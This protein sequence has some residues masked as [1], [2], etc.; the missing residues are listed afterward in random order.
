[1]DTTGLTVRKNKDQR[2]E[3]IGNYIIFWSAVHI[4]KKLRDEVAQ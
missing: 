4:L 3:V 2:K 1:M